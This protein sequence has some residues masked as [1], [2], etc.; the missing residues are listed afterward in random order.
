MK[1]VLLP[2]LLIFL[3]LSLE[4]QLTFDYY[5]P[6]TVIYNS[7]IPSP[8]KF[9]GFEPGEWHLSHDKLYSYM[10]ELAKTSDR[11]V[12][13][14]Y[15]KSYEKRPLG[16]LIISST[17][18]IRNLEMLRQ[19]HL[20][21]SDPSQS[22]KLSIEKMP[23]FIKLGYGI[24]GN[25]SSA[26]NA[27]VLVAYYLIAGEGDQ[28]DNILKNMVILIDPSLNPDGMQRHSSWVNSTRSLNNNPDPASWEFS[29]PWPGGR[30]NHYWFDLNRDYIMLQHPES[31]GRLAAYYRWRPDLITDHHETGPGETFFFQPGVPGRNNPL[32]PAKNYELTA[33]IGK[34][35]QKY[36]DSIGSLY[37]TEESFDDYYPGKGSSYPD[38]HGSVGI[39]F[40]QAGVKGHL[41]ETPGGLLSFPF[42]I[43]NHF[44]VSLST[45]EAGLKMKEKLLE[46][47]RAFYISSLTLADKYPVKA[48]VFKE[49]CDS[50]RISE[51]INILLQHHIK[52]FH[53]SRNIEK[54]GI[55]YESGKSFVVPLKQPEF[56]FIRSLFESVT[57]FTDSA[58]YD[59]S[60]WNLPMSLN[61][62]FAPVV[63]TREM[64]GLTG[65]E[66]TGAPFP[67]GK[68]VAAKDPYVFMFEWSDFLSPKA[69]Y[70]LQDK[71]LITRV[72]TQEFVIEE[73]SL[74]KTFSAGTI[75][76]SSAGQPVE[77]TDLYNLMEKTAK[78]CSITIYGVSS[79]LTKKGID[80]GSSNII[81]LNKPSV[82][83][84]IGEGVNSSVAG[85]VW[86]LLD[87]RLKMPVTMIRASQIGSLNLSR[88]NV[89]IIN[90]S[91]DISQA[92][93]EKLKSW[94]Q[95]G[96]V[97]I[98]IESGNRW[99][100]KN[101]FADIE[102]IPEVSP[103]KSDGV[104]LNKGA[105]NQVQQIPGTIF[106][107]RLD[108]THPLCY[109]FTGETLPVFKSLPTA[110]RKDSNAYNNPV[111]YTDNPLLS[112][113]CSRQNLERVR[114]SS[115][116][117]VHSS[118]I[119]SIYD[120]PNFR[121]I[122]YGTN[123]IFINA[124]CFGQILR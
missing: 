74:N 22:E 76:I 99:L 86:H 65:S 39:L 30:T 110:V 14:E 41:R 12:W 90:G 48:F 55:N 24:H 91:P 121:A 115:Y 116:A 25:E 58:F 11:A 16:Q 29:E 51:F 62:T 95:P 114:G 9:F 105:D 18:N 77:G 6:K 43:R 67:S 92:G 108:L 122:W 94:N 89:M 40:E 33:E 88:Y 37:Y 118:R 111:S 102:F 4:A 84:V 35:H 53:S 112:G 109:G 93:I 36:L 104:Y 44:T 21:L 106:S 124:V 98:G 113:F 123:R 57:D 59:I 52:V 7:D 83:M 68:L 42:A 46:N 75:V 23:L 5:L 60:T 117:S 79:G 71:G 13:E 56:L 27:S 3:S 103:K 1:R 17:E 38:I 15:G 119:I 97:I 61:I 70:S 107:T 34:Y 82:V 49:P 100:N 47:Q 28:I 120:D 87:Y 63:N 101:K 64:E 50:S 20:R 19:E 96:K 78:E 10:L 2:L 54:G 66:V 8:G 85:E 73:G 69:L 72:S 26:Q 32:T 81:V 31:K 80:L 45:I